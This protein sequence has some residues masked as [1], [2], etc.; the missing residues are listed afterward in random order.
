MPLA[1]SLKLSNSNGGLASLRRVIEVIRE[2]RSISR[3]GIAAATGLSTPS[4]TRLVNEL[5]E[6]HILKVVENGEPAT[7]GPGRPASSV[8]LNPSF[9]SSI[10]VDVGEHTIRAGIGDMGGKIQLTRQ[11]QLEVG[12]EDQSFACLVNVIRDLKKQFEE[13]LGEAAPPLRAITVCVPGAVDPGSSVIKFA[14]NIPGWKNFPAK[15]LLQKEFP[16]IH[17]RVEN[18]VNA[19]AIGEWSGGRAQ[20]KGSFV[21][22]SFRAGIGAGI[23]ING[24]LFRGYSGFAGELGKLVFDPKFQFSESSGLGHLETLASEGPVIEHATARGVA[25]SPSTGRRPEL[26]DLCVAANKGDSAALDV[27]NQALEHYA[28]ATANVA[29]LFDPELI[30]IGGELNAVLDMAVERIRK[31]VQQL[32]PFVPEIEGAAL[33]ENSA[34]R[35]AF[36]QAHKDNCETLTLKQG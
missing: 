9:G 26:K 15:E 23:F 2:S 4:I 19:A 6:A 21:Y 30:V 17:V 1:G 10:G 3:R 22:M 11:M 7:P 14:P 24:R 16:S 8:T 18:D 13:E 12:E 34:L 31:R 29:C 33:G 36:Y 28:V 25:L 35:G 27:L 20:G 32:V 5:I